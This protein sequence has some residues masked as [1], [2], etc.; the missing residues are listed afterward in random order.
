MLVRLYKFE[1]VD[2]HL[3]RITA[4]DANNEVVN[5]QRKKASGVYVPGGDTSVVATAVR[6]QNA[7]AKVSQSCPEILHSR[8]PC[9]SYPAL[10]AV[11]AVSA[12]CHGPG[13]NIPRLT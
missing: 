12:S 7:A 4:V 13:Y 10:C 3:L 1:P 6:A 9:N 8:L 5:R 11:S 2:W